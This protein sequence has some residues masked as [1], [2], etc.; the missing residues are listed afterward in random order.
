MPPKTARIQTAAAR[1]A[2]DAAAGFLFDEF[3]VEQLYTA[4]TR[5][6]DPDTTLMK[7]GISRDKLRALEGDDEISAAL[8]TRREALVSTPWRLEPAEGDAVEWLWNELTPHL[9]SLLRG[10]WEAVPYGYSVIEIVYKPG[11]RIG[12][13][14]A[15]HKPI[16]WFAP[17]T[18]GT[19]VWVGGTTARSGQGELLDPRKFLLTRRNPSY[20]QPYGEALLSRLYWPWFFRHNAWRFWMQYLERFGTPFILGNVTSP[21]AFVDA[22][23]A[24]GID[25]VIGVDRDDKV[26]AVTQ[27]AAGEFERVESALSRRI[28]KVILGQTLTSDVSSNGGSYAAAKVHGDV[29]DDK[30]AADARLVTNT[31]QRLV[32]TLWTLNNFPGTPP[33]FVLADERGIETDRAKRDA[34][35][36][37]AGVRPTEQYLTRVYDFEPGDVTIDKQSTAQQNPDD[38]SAEEPKAAAS[39]PPRLAAAGGTFTGYQRHV[40]NVGDAAMADAGQPIDPAQIRAAVRAATDA[41]DLRERLAV[42]LIDKTRIQ[43]EVA[44]Q[45]AIIA[46]EVLGYVHADD[47][48]PKPAEATADPLRVRELDLQERT[49]R[50]LERDQGDE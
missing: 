47:E 17:Q 25:T 33:S 16:E 28:Q 39:S 30:R 40:E 14:R 36:A 50:M 15:S 8:E 26:Q 9:D 20:R 46:A 21:K 38:A 44:V 5:L 27:A 35:L 10:A 19:L 11:A 1:R 12:I 37:K 34:D 22:V 24:L 18:D 31:I 7:A 49:L 48:G 32:S 41:D 3:A 2:E 43:F 23:T 6:P 42:L 4:L 45:R 13:E 29:R